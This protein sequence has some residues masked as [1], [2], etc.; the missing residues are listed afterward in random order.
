MKF[1]LPSRI[2]EMTSWLMDM[3]YLNS[4]E[5][6]ALDHLNRV[7][8]FIQIFRITLWTI[9]MQCREWFKYNVMDHLYGLIR[10]IYHAVIWSIMI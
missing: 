1:D 4:Y 2:I 9:D 8:G 7:F 6:N 5:N 10:I 3:R